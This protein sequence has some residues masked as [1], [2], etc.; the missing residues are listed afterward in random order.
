MKQ[1][2]ITIFI[3]HFTIQVKCQE[4][5][6]YKELDYIKY[7]P[8]YKETI[9]TNL[10]FTENLNLFLDNLDTTSK[11]YKKLNSNGNSRI[12]SIKGDTIKS[13]K[14]NFKTHEFVSIELFVYNPQRKICFY[15]D[16]TDYYFDK[17]NIPVKAVQFFYNKNEL[18]DKLTYYHQT[19]MQQ[20]N[21]YSTFIIDQYKLTS[22]I[23]YTYKTSKQNLIIFGKECMGKESY[24]DF[25]TTLIDNFGYI[26]KYNS[27]AKQ[28]ALGCPMGLHV[29]DTYE[30]KYLKDSV[31]IIFTRTHCFGTDMQGNCV[32][33]DE[34]Q[35]ET[36]KRKFIKLNYNYFDCM[37]MKNRII[38]TRKNEYIIF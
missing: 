20:I 32:G 24:R 28:R 13:L 30:Y 1:F 17:K 12:Y 18:V 10:I 37:K 2:L 23:H 33:Q 35:T 7:Y 15:I 8:F 34:P 11:I 19:Y 36:D 31:D 21:F 16:C 4:F 3:L 22:A 26:K 27:F 29:N 5:N 14:Y 38:E 25:D 9:D 6:Y